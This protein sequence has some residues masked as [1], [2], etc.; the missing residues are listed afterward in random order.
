MCVCVSET[1][2]VL[3]LKQTQLWCCPCD[4]F[5]PWSINLVFVSAMSHTL[6]STSGYQLEHV[7]ETDSVVVLSIRLPSVS[8]YELDL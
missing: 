4:Y 2:P 3:C 8:G 5:V 1:D 6:L 7:S